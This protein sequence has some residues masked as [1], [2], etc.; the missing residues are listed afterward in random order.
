MNPSSTNP[1]HDLVD[2][3]FGE[4]CTKFEETDEFEDFLSGEKP[5]GGM[6][7]P[8]Q[9][10]GD[11]I[12]GS[13]GGFSLSTPA[14]TA[15]NQSDSL[16]DFSIPA[17]EKPAESPKSALPS[18][19]NLSTGLKKLSLLDDDWSFDLL[20]NQ[21]NNSKLVDSFTQPT[22]ILGKISPKLPTMNMLPIH[23]HSQEDPEA[24]DMN[25]WSN[26][27]SLAGMLGG[28]SE[29]QDV[30]DFGDFTS[31][32]TS[33]ELHGFEDFVGHH[34][35]R[36]GG[37]A[38]L[39]SLLDL[40]AEVT[41]PELPAIPL[42]FAQYGQELLDL[43]K[44]S[45][46]EEIA[47]QKADSSNNGGDENSLLN[48]IDWT[49]ATPHSSSSEHDGVKS[50]SLLP[51]PLASVISLA[52]KASEPEFGGFTS[53]TLNNKES[54][55]SFFA[56]DGSPADENETS[57]TRRI[58]APS[59]NNEA[60][61][62]M[63]EIL[64]FPEPLDGT[65]SE[66]EEEPQFEPDLICKKWN[67]TIPTIFATPQTPASLEGLVQNSPSN[68]HLRSKPLLLRSLEENPRFQWA[69]SVNEERHLTS[70]NLKKKKKKKAAPLDAPSIQ[71]LISVQAADILIDTE[72]QQPTTIASARQSVELQVPTLTMSLS[73]SKLT[74]YFGKEEEEKEKNR[75]SGSK[76]PIGQSILSIFQP[77]TK[78]DK[79]KRHTQMSFEVFDATELFS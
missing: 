14:H 38:G 34:L 78:K 50:P 24:K 36:D 58:A 33:A 5:S 22:Q 46:V 66:I 62:E 44:S 20:G 63:D 37:K 31:H 77:T 3:D 4:Y 26:S 75:L 2:L 19:A 51:A 23:T 7:T 59:D 11:D 40:S 73:D 53:H 71:E 39:P 61:V 48:L 52:K 42:S 67:S 1:T 27:A 49:T 18:Q 70:L 13:T 21:G 10:D 43:G 54:F 64:Q 30:G 8:L 15:G 29:E 45:A 9:V 32:R 6:Q 57:S 79:S 17:S 12:W 72:P 41:I 16:L 35:S 68:E 55:G 74:E 47:S 56:E 65:F 28:T 69:D 25:P 60:P 76:F